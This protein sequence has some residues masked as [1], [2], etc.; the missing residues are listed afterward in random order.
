VASPAQK[1]AFIRVIAT[2]R[3]RTFVFA[4]ALRRHFKALGLDP[5][6]VHYTPMTFSSGY[7]N[8]VVV[9]AR[10]N[11]SLWHAIASWSAGHFRG[12]HVHDVIRAQLERFLIY[13]V[14]GEEL[15]ETSVTC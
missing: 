8:E 11:V 4:R 15:Y 13:G 12:L 9:D 2:G 1:G 5:G 14:T 10:L 6:L 7:L 3:I